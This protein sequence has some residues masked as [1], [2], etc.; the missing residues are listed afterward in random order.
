[1]GGSQPRSVPS[2][3]TAVVVDVVEDL[4]GRL[5]VLDALERH[6]AVLGHLLVALHPLALVDA[7]VVALG[8]LSAAVDLGERIEL[9]AGGGR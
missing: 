1:M 3:L 5:L 4:L 9:E 7:A 2:E 8:A 6:E